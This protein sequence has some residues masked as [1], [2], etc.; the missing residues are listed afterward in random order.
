MRIKTLRAKNGMLKQILS[1]SMLTLAAF[2]IFGSRIYALNP[3]PLP[4]GAFPEHQIGRK[5][6]GEQ[7][8]Y[9][10]SSVTG[11][12]QGISTFEPPDPC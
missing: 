7:I 1:I 10:A 2:A 3:Q 12:K 4:P 9:F 6:G 11:T 5:A 8:E